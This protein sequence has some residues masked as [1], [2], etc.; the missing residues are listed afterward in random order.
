MLFF[1]DAGDPVFFVEV[2]AVFPAGNALP[3]A[4]FFAA[5]FFVGFFPVP[6]P[7]DPGEDFFEEGLAA[8]FFLEVFPVL[9]WADVSSDSLRAMRGQKAAGHRIIQLAFVSGM[10]ETLRSGS[11]YRTESE[12]KSSPGSGRSAKPRQRHGY[13]TEESELS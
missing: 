10:R 5:D 1:F 12:E 11:I 13:H 9:F 2:R 8:A 4:V 6:E 3:V 7:A